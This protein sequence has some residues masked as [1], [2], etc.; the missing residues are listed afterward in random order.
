MIFM[1]IQTT[2]TWNIRK[3]SRIN[4]TKE[5]KPFNY[6]LCCLVTE[7]GNMNQKGQTE[8]TKLWPC[9][10]E[11]VSYSQGVGKNVLLKADYVCMKMK[12]I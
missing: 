5:K 1:F 6:L 10:L 2:V 7:E 9:W 11:N 4:I 3:V 8:K 12:S